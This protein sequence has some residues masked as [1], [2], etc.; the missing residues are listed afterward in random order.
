MKPFAFSP[1]LLATVLFFLALPKHLVLAQ[2]YERIEDFAVTS[3][4]KLG[5][6]NV[7]YTYAVAFTYQ[8]TA[9]PTV[10]S[11]ILRFTKGDSNANTFGNLALAVHI[12]P[13]TLRLNIT[14]GT[15]TQTA[16]SFASSNSMSV[17][18]K[19][20]IRLT[21]VDSVVTAW[22]NG[23][24]TSFTASDVWHAGGHLYV[25]DPWTASAGGT[26]SDLVVSENFQHLY[27]RGFPIDPV[28]NKKIGLINI[29]DDWTF[30]MTVT[31]K[32][33][34]ANL[35]NLVHL[36]TDNTNST[37]VGS[38]LFAVHF[39]PGTTKLRI[40][41]AATSNGAWAIEPNYALPMN[42][43][44][45]VKISAVGTTVTVTINDQVFSGTTPSA[46]VTGVAH[47]YL[48]DP[49]NAAASATLRDVQ[50][51]PDGQ[52]PSAIYSN[53]AA[54][55]PA[56]TST[57]TDINMS[58]NYVI[59]FNVKPNSVLSTESN[60]FTIVNKD[61]DPATNPKT[62]SI[63]FL[64]SSTRLYLRH[65]LSPGKAW[66]VSMKESLPVGVD[67]HV[68]LVFD[69]SRILVRYN[70][71]KTVEI[72]TD[73]QRFSGL[74]TLYTSMAGQTAAAATLSD[75]DIKT[76]VRT[77]VPVDALASMQTIFKNDYAGIFDV[78]DDYILEFTI[79]PTAAAPGTANV[80]ILHVTPDDTDGNRLIQFNLKQG[81][82][83]LDYRMS[84]NGN[85]AWSGF[86]ATALPL[87]T[88]TTVKM[89][90]YGNRLFFFFN[91]DLVDEVVV[92]HQ[93]VF[94][95]G[96]L[97]L[98]NNYLNAASA[99]IAAVTIRNAYQVDVPV[100]RR[101]NTNT[102]LDS[103]NGDLLTDTAVAVSSCAS[104][105]DDMAQ[106]VGYTAITATTGC[107]YKFAFNKLDTSTTNS[108]NLDMVAAFPDRTFRDYQCLT[109]YQ[110]FGN[111]IRTFTSTSVTTCKHECNEFPGCSS[112]QYDTATSSCTL[113][114]D[115]TEVYSAASTVS[116]CTFKVA[117]PERRAYTIENGFTYGGVD[118]FTFV[119]EIN[120]CGQV[121]DKTAGCVGYVY[122][123]D[124]TKS[125]FLKSAMGSKWAATNRIAYT[126]VSGRPSFPA[127]RSY[128]EAEN[129]DFNAKSD[130]DGPT[131]YFT[132]T[133]A[134]C[135]AQCDALPGC[136]AYVLNLQGGGS[137]CWFKT[138]PDAING[139]G[140]TVRTTFLS[141]TGYRGRT[142]TTS[143]LSGGHP[144]YRKDRILSPNRR[145]A[146]RIRADG[147]VE[148][149]FLSSPLKTES[150]RARLV[151]PHVDGRLKIRW[152]S[153]L[154]Q[155]FGTSSTCNG[156]VAGTW[157][158]TVGDDG[159]FRIIA[160]G[161][162]ITSWDLGVTSANT[163][164]W[165][166]TA[167][168]NV[169][170]TTW[171][172][173]RNRSHG[174]GTKIYFLDSG[175]NADLDAS[176]LTSDDTT[177]RY[178]EISLNAGIN[179]D[180]DGYY[181]GATLINIAKSNLS[182]IAE[183]ASVAMI[184]ITEGDS[185]Y[186]SELNFVKAVAAVDQNTV[187]AGTTKIINFSGR[188]VNPPNAVR[189]ATQWA[190]FRNI[191][192]IRAVGN[193]NALFGSNNAY[194]LSIGAFEN[195]ALGNSRIWAE[196]NYGGIVDLWAPGVY[197]DK[198]RLGSS[199]ATAY[200]SAAA[201][202]A[203]SYWPA[204][205]SN[206]PNRVLQYLMDLARTDAI[207]PTQTKLSTGSVGTQSL[208]LINIK[209]LAPS[210][211]VFYNLANEPDYCAMVGINSK[212]VPQWATLING[213]DPLKFGTIVNSGTPG[214]CQTSTGTW[215][216]C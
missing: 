86:V 15:R 90:A 75:F 56:A 133:H 82:S 48:S 17:N 161:C 175:A 57:G 187:P 115:Y 127:T 124:S 104:V 3:G 81:T 99:K 181:H 174:A 156:N 67:T 191:I 160:S 123:Y 147:I 33:T 179:F 103:T 74:A 16:V 122:A 180:S 27:S 1:W 210:T 129:I 166:A 120:D 32:A 154:E 76:A 125:C 184:K 89:I 94:G 28:A 117:T 59:S 13:N 9:T 84:L 58:T 2:I 162:S 135:P 202:A 170:D 178:E 36:S 163:P 88:F 199:Y 70:F 145:Y 183:G 63:G 106:C 62:P 197:V 96:Y 8:P 80:N 195:Y 47:F 208:S 118:M 126:L 155:F 20:Y 157:A 207:N 152:Q 111:A 119:G 182:G 113:K 93:R 97:Y 68:Q 71:T 149:A 46:R 29:D 200:V 214:M 137:G 153:G 171:F 138:Y 100:I 141:Q 31:P 188:F 134:N 211:A 150:D 98:S 92:P 91:N 87:N 192:F 34:N 209:T 186:F 148:Y 44:S 77:D 168:Y 30:L 49:W 112:F 130:L 95:Q 193:D 164:Y 107:R 213:A 143:I 139:T 196:S 110:S 190:F 7:P 203:V 64:A 85:T 136:T 172:S 19:N 173:S 169:S 60:L 72:K 10:L 11:N 38:R 24:S 201:A 194:T 21:F 140:S 61:A 53:A 101:Y 69:N 78:P 128:V 215:Y 198:N 52:G 165:P 14:I 151:K 132:G 144:L 18:A 121:C 25:S 35:A 102:L 83:Q 109:G 43:E 146:L 189:C 55:T 65:D 177:T 167:I 159:R 114:R 42:T 45:R 142:Y 6:I 39:V 51:I 22:V 216:R 37:S 131:T 205:L 23:V 116:F 105:C 73:M 40:H 4:A 108:Y 212:T 204:Q 5:Y 158:L 79:N 66:G 50:M 206:N 12:N 41:V 176:S 185:R 26:L 54:V